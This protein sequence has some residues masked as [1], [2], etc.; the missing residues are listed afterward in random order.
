M[1]L[2]EQDLEEAIIALR[3]AAD[4]GVFPTGDRLFV[5]AVKPL[6]AEMKRRS[7]A[8]VAAHID[9]WHEDI[10][11]VL[12]WRFPVEEPPYVGSPLEDDFPDY[13]THWTPIVMPEGG[14]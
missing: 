11:T 8:A 1:A 13:V 3:Y 12:W 2:S 4:G 9:S 6:V 7:A 5:E 14:E 10:G